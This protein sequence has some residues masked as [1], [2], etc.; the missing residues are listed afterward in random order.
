[1]SRSAVVS[2]ILRVSIDTLGCSQDLLVR[3]R[4]ADTASRTS[5][6]AVAVG[7]DIDVVDVASGRGQV[8]VQQ[9]LADAARGRPRRVQGFVE[10]V[11]SCL[12][13]SEP[14]FEGGGRWPVEFVPSCLASASLP[15][16]SVLR[17]NKNKHAQHKNKINPIYPIYCGTSKIRDAWILDTVIHKR[18]DLKGR[19]M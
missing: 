17:Q 5:T 7:S 11:V 13:R 19:M 6:A 16:P 10:M 8:H 12:Y 3:G 1:M 14:A 9:R 15:S 2:G 18:F 4:G